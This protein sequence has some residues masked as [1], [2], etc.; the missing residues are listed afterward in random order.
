MT[1]EATFAYRPPVDLPQGRSD[2][3]YEADFGF[4]YR[5]L[6]ERASARLAIRDPFGLRQAGVRTQ[7]ISY[8]QIGRSRESTRSAQISIS[9]TF[10]GQGRR[11]GDRRR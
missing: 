8:I 11:R 2:A 10:G 3:S 5:F 6:G 9:Y 7:D 4:R 1:A